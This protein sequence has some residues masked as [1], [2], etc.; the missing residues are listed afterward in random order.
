MPYYKGTNERGSMTTTPLLDNQYEAI[1]PTELASA[2]INNDWSILDYIND[3]EYEKCINQYLAELNAE[4]YDVVDVLDDNS[5]C[6]Y[7]DMTEYG[8][9]PCDCSTFILQK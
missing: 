2:F 9:L 4:G 8:V 1:L 7:H 3:K 6:H 5:F